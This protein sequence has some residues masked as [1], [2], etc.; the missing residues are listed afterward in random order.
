MILAPY[1]I[2]SCL[3]PCCLART[4]RRR[5]RGQMRDRAQYDNGGDGYLSHPEG[6]RLQ[7]HCH[8]ALGWWNRFLWTGRISAA[9]PL[10]SITLIRWIYM[11]GSSP[12]KRRSSCLWSTT[13][14]GTGSLV[15]TAFLVW[16]GIGESTAGDEA[17]DTTVPACIWF[18]S[19][20]AC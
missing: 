1:L 6:R 10:S 13:I 8:G 14:R 4:R 16:K 3:S 15:S 19:H 18:G 17:T 12:F 9:V 11:Q 20:E 5:D 7:E 2:A